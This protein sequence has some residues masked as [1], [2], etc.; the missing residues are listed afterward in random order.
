MR[1]NKAIIYLRFIRAHGRLSCQKD[2]QNS[3]YK[4]VGDAIMRNVVLASVPSRA[5]KTDW[6]A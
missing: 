3:N 5:H 2:K 1:Q 6:E 4:Y